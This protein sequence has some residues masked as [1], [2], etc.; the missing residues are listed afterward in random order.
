MHMPKY[1]K[2]RWTPEEDQLLS[3]SVM[4]NGTSNWSLVSMSLK[5]RT[6]KQ[7]RER[8]INHLSPGLKTNIWTQQEDQQLL[9]LIGVHGHQWAIISR[10]F[11]GRSTNSVKNR[12]GWLKRHANYLNYTMM[13]AKIYHSPRKL[14]DVILSSPS[15]GIPL[16]PL[17]SPSS[18]E[19]SESESPISIPI[20]LNVPNS[21]IG[22][23]L[24]TLNF[25][26]NNVD[27]N[28]TIENNSI[29]GEGVTNDETTKKHIYFPQLPFTM[30]A[31]PRFNFSLLLA[32]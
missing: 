27:K 15:S 5:N 12:W 19:N 14:P 18:S 32:Q 13:K 24:S 21:N 10:Y 9:T 29:E 30:Q 22:V 23:N 31:D 2:N 7:C 8:W 25:I 26:K 16:S 3:E 11:V 20:N 17:S 1:T 4:K 28:E 6:G